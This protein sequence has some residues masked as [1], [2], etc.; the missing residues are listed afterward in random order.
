MRPAPTTALRWRLVPPLPD[1][2]LLD[3]DESE[4]TIH[5]PGRSRRLL[6][7]HGEVYRAQLVAA[8]HLVMWA[9]RI[10]NRPAYG[11]DERHLRGFM[12]GLL[13]VAAHLRQGDYLPGGRLYEDEEGRVDVAS[14]S[15]PPRRARER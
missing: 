5:E 9:D 12:N 3:F 2:D 13:E 4:L 8:R 14:F 15:R 6:D 1:E 7:E 11:V 10:E